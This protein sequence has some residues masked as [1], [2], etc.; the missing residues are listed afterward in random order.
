MAGG[1]VV[2]VLGDDVGYG[3]EVGSCLAA[4][5]VQRANVLLQGFVEGLAFV[6]GK[7]DIGDRVNWMSATIGSW[8]RCGSWV[9]ELGTDDEVDSIIFLVH[10]NHQVIIVIVSDISKINS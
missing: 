2:I 10:V 5:P 8:F 9:I 1:A 6:C 7:V 4:E 3:G